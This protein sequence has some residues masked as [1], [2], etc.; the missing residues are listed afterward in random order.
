[1]S[2][3]KGKAKAEP[4]PAGQRAISAFFSKGPAKPAPAAEEQPASKKQR[5]AE[6]KKQEDAPPAMSAK[7]QALSSFSLTSTPSPI[8]PPTRAATASPGASGAAAAASAGPSSS[9]FHARPAAEA[10]PERVPKR[11]ADDVLAELGP[12]SAARHE[13][14][15]AKVSTLGPSRGARGTGA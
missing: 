7:A 4:P 5:T 11:S 9:R 1:M 12:G 2:S 8:V 6:A 14:F 10:T 13:R 3:G 15:V